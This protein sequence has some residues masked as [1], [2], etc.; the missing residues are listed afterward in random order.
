MPETPVA[1]VTPSPAPQG[2]APAG[3]SLSEAR[4]GELIQEALNPLSG[5]LRKLT[6]Q[7]TEAEPA[8]SPAEKTLTERLRAIEAREER[9]SQRARETAI[10]ETA[11][12]SGVDP[13]RAE[14]LL[15]HIE[16]RHGRR[17]QVDD[18]GGA[19]YIDEF[20]QGQP[21]EGWMKKFLSTPAGEIFKAPT[22]VPGGKSLKGGQEPN[23]NRP[24]F[25]ELSEE[26]RGKMS[27]EDQRAY[28]ADDMRRSK[29]QR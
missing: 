28:V 21:L 17:I 15:D 8:K 25:Y 7:K 22:S 13:S 3:S 10:R 5:M 27:K 6:N 23:G 4:V 19:S 11:L 29:E 2:E 12:A 24:F 16:R 18:M 9:Q 20:D 1:P 26:A 14:Y